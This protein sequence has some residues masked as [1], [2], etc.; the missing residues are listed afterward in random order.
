MGTLS[1]SNDLT[2]SKRRCLFL[3]RRYDLDIRRNLDGMRISWA[4]SVGE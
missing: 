3:N 1:S 4:V 2:D